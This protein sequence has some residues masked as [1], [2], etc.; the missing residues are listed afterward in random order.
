MSMSLRC[1]GWHALGPPRQAE[2][3]GLLLGYMAQALA[4]G[5]APFGVVPH[6]V[7]GFDPVC[8]MTL[9][10]RH[11]LF[12][13]NFTIE[14][15][16]G[17]GKG[18]CM[19][20]PCLV[21]NHGARSQCR[22]SRRGQ[23]MPKSQRSP[24]GRRSRWSRWAAQRGARA[25]EVVGSHCIAVAAPVAGADGVA[26]HVAVI[27]DHA[28]PC[29]AAVQDLPEL[30]VSPRPVGSPGP[31]GPPLSRGSLE[32]GRELWSPQDRRSPCSRRNP[33]GSRRHAAHGSGAASGH[34]TCHPLPLWGAWVES[35]V[36]PAAGRRWGRVAR[37]AESSH[38]PHPDAFIVPRV[39]APHPSRRS[40]QVAARTPE[41]YEEYLRWGW[42]SFHGLAGHLHSER[43]YSNSSGQFS[44]N[45]KTHIEVLQI[46][47]DDVTKTPFLGAAPPWD[48]GMVWPNY[49]IKP[50]G[51]V[52]D[53]FLDELLFED[54]LSGGGVSHRGSR[55]GPCPCL[56]VLLYEPCAMVSCAVLCFCYVL[57]C[58]D[59][60]CC[61]VL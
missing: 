25:H 50:D 12:E 31:M 17:W 26:G 39:A 57:L 41:V 56:P 18:V 60:L 45:R 22:R 61:S 51:S 42:P 4:E 44:G 3:Q 1:S 9:Y 35:G 20:K 13:K 36:R 10:L 34:C 15:V 46:R 7:G 14:Q 11:Q 16:V 33:L 6:L 40:P 53:G 37:R 49:E 43:M 52:I 58:C 55:R 5:G 23:R 59:V 28:N 38:A 27:M 2:A 29:F 21:A 24:W 47:G 19:R 32:M 30:I 54:S 8:L 48:M